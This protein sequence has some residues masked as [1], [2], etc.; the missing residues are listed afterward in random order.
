MIT[1]VVNVVAIVSK[2]K[3]KLQFIFLDGSRCSEGSSEMKL[4]I[5]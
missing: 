3:L 4:Q 2:L 5:F 1:Y